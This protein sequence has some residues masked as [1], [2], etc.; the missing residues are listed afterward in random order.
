MDV[1][2]NQPHARHG[3]PRN[4]RYARVAK[5]RLFI[6]LGMLVPLFGCLQAI[7]GGGV[8]QI[9]VRIVQRD[10]PVEVPV[11]VVVERVVDRFVFVSFPGIGVQNGMLARWD[12][13][14]LPVAGTPFLRV[15]QA[16]ARATGV[17]VMPQIGTTPFYWPADQVARFPGTPA[18]ANQMSDPGSVT[19]LFT[20]SVA[21]ASGANLQSTYLG[22]GPSML[23]GPFGVRSPS[24]A[25]FRP[26]G[27]NGSGSSTSAG[28]RTNS[29]AVANA[30]S[31]GQGLLIAPD[32][33]LVPPGGVVL[34]PAGNQPLMLSV[35]DPSPLLSAASVYGTPTPTMVPGLV[36]RQATRQTRSNNNDNQNFVAALSLNDPSTGSGT[37]AGTGSGST[38]PVSPPSSALGPTPE[39]G[40][41][42][43]NVKTPTSTPIPQPTETPRPAPSETP[44][45]EQLPGDPI[46]PTS[47]PVPPTA[48]PHPP[49]AT[50][51]P[52]TAT[53]KPPTSTPVPSATPKP[54][55]ATPKPP[56]ATAVPPT[57]TKQ[58][59]AT[60][61]VVT[62]PSKTPTPKAA[63]ATP[64]PPTATPVPPTATPKVAPTKTPTP[65][66]ATPTPKPPTATP[67]PPTATPKRA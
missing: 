50:P 10:M 62:A 40:S 19:S 13:S 16:A 52:P 64:K 25:F 39:S 4:E 44:K 60:P 7:A 48:T 22:A 5:I 34:A 63:T 30:P 45:P 33:S 2:S 46:R 1:V 56:T 14:R 57:A 59:T 51:V 53:P 35:A 29:G 8:P 49:T 18:Q 38:S 66:A 41:N 12:I 17:T 6:L 23:T 15:A 58:A 61:K 28:A 20:G 24:V 55:T 47:T 31:A 42:L 65:K 37:G 21:S 26:N 67:K 54:P 3:E 36:R 11:E 27:S 43:P 32:G 9:E